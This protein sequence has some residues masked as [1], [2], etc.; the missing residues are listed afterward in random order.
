MPRVQIEPGA[1]AAK[2]IGSDANLL[3]RKV[4]VKS[5]LQT[6]KIFPNN[7]AATLVHEKDSGNCIISRWRLIAPIRIETPFVVVDAMT[8]R[9]SL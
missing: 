1:E 9:Y 5:R 3:S 7:D 2:L 4:L 6:G 8:R